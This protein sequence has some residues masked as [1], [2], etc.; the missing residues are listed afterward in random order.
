MRKCLVVIAFT[1][2]VALCTYLALHGCELGS[3]TSR[4]VESCKAWDPPVETYHAAYA[5]ENGV[6]LDYTVRNR[7]DGHYRR[8][9][10]RYWATLR[11]DRIDRTLIT[12]DYNVRRSPLRDKTKKALPLIDL[13]PVVA[14][15]SDG[16]RKFD[17][18]LAYI[19]KQPESD[20]P[21]VYIVSD[22]EWFSLYIRYRNPD[23]GRLD[24]Y[25]NAPHGVFFPPAR[26][27]KL[28]FGYLFALIL[29][30][31]FL[32]KWWILAAIS[33]LVQKF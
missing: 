13:A 5:I 23:S 20:L 4:L 11:L 30:V 3:N 25:R 29:D 32:L 19:N 31:I 22:E 10:D 8:Y 17:D 16:H 2:Y 1:L 27:P 21:Q 33:A 15:A 6:L 18:V 12:N 9:A 28:I 7:S 14:R 24:V 26:C